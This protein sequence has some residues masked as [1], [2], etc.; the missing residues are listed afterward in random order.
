[1]NKKATPYAKGKI[2]RSANNLNLLT[3]ARSASG[4][5]TCVPAPTLPF[6]TLT[7][8]GNGLPQLGQK[9]S[10]SA[11]SRPQLEHAFIPSMTCAC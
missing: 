2:E 8:A 1:M 5:K 6:G 10:V 4:S 9:L 3:A 11:T 7:I